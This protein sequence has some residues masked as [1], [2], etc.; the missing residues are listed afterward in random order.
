MPLC[1]SDAWRQE[2]HRQ[3]QAL[4]G[5]PKTFLGS[6]LPLPD[7]IAYASEAADDAEVY[8]SC[9]VA[10]LV[11]SIV[12]VLY[13]LGDEEKHDTFWIAT[14]LP[15]PGVDLLRCFERVGRPLSTQAGDLKLAQDRANRW[16][17]LNYVEP[18][19]C[20]NLQ[21]RDWDYTCAASA[22]DHYTDRRHPYATMNPTA[23]VHKVLQAL[24]DGVTEC[25][26]VGLTQLTSDRDVRDMYTVHTENW[27]LCVQWAAEFGKLSQ[28]LHALKPSERRFVPPLNLPPVPGTPLKTE[29]GEL[30]YT[31]LGAPPLSMLWKPMLTADPRVAF[32][33]FFVGKLPL[34]VQGTLMAWI[35]GGDVR[36][37]LGSAD[38][39]PASEDKIFDKYY[40]NRNTLLDDFMRSGCLTHW[41][42][43]VMHNVRKTISRCIHVAAE[44]V[45]MLRELGLSEDP[46]D[47]DVYRRDQRAGRAESDEDEEE[48]QGEAEWEAAAAASSAEGA[49]VFEEATAI[50]DALVDAVTKLRGYTLTAYQWHCSMISGGAYESDVVEQGNIIIAAHKALPAYTHTTHTAAKYVLH[51]RTRSSRR[52]FSSATSTS[53][54]RRRCRSVRR[55][56]AARRSRLVATPRLLLGGVSLTVCNGQGA[57]LHINSAANMNAANLTTF[58]E[59][60]TTCVGVYL[61]SS[62]RTWACFF[63]PIQ[64]C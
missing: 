27:R 32:D 11:V 64:V 51:H 40:R 50:E 23:V 6:A 45:R 39:T 47:D 24:P 57:V 52:H 55:W 10:M 13:I 12:P 17:H 16:V 34:V 21:M 3:R 56:A 54:W 58:R 26:V 1:V 33:E 48:R 35:F 19:K 61:G 44:D 41:R 15:Q 38:Q 63:W 30:C 36:E 7:E 49:E 29:D 43:S 5:T 22:I 4:S 46:N 9:D 8:V 2:R 42:E 60:F 37:F 20:Y 25:C 18:F 31:L 14:V 59:L 28:A 53:T 62:N